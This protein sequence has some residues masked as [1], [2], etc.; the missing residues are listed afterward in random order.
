MVRFTNK[1]KD[2]PPMHQVYPTF[3]ACFGSLAGCR[4]RNTLPRIACIL[5]LLVLGTPER[6][7]DFQTWDSPI[8][9]NIDLFSF[10]AIRL[11]F[12]IRVFIFPL[13]FFPL[14]AFGFIHKHLSIV[15][16]AYLKPLKWSRS[17]TFKVYACHSE[18]TTVARAFK[19]IV[20]C[21]PI[22]CAP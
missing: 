13:T 16:N 19:F 4:C 18:T 10:S 2:K 9:S 7:I 5:C 14:E 12:Q 15:C 22:R 6:M 11:N 20:S 3:T 1:K 8:F 17:G 21:K